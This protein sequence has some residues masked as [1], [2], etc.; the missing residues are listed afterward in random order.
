M[1]TVAI[2]PNVLDSLRHIDSATVANA[3][4]H[5][6]VRDPVIGYGAWTVPCQFP[7][8][9]PMVGYAITC[10]ADTTTAG[11][12]RPMQLH[13][14]LDLIHD[15]PGP[16]VLLVQNA[17]LDRQRSCIIGDMFAATLQKL[18]VVGMVTDMGGRDFK[19]IQ[20]RAPGFQLFSPGSVAS[21]GYGVFLDFNQTVSIGG[22]TI[23]PGDL[24]HGDA[25]GIVQIPPTI[26]A[27][28]APQATKILAEEQAFFDF[29]DSP[30]FSYEA[31][32]QRLGRQE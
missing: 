30:N 26:A 17:G 28:I 21:H 23:Q 14:L 19:G 3:I 6:C 7:E 16:I 11:D 15:T 27:D 22:M 29:L 10:R 8:H 13:T 5:F 2:A 24:L 18:G 9:P 1:T 31:L 20:Q 12:T 4:E 25:N 32:K